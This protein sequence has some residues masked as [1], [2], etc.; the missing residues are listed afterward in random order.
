MQLKRATSK[1]STTSQEENKKPKKQRIREIIKQPK[2]KF[3]TKNQEQ[4]WKTL[5]DNE[6]TLCFGP[7]G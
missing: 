6:I 5:S 7:A 1:N 2:E 4:Y 3:L